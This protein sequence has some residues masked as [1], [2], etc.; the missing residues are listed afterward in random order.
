[1]NQCATWPDGRGLD[2]FE[3]TNKKRA[4]RDWW[5]WQPLRNFEDRLPH[6]QTI[7]DFVSE[8]LNEH[9]LTAAPT[10]SR[11]ELIRRLYFDL[12]GLPPSF[13]DVCSIRSRQFSRCYERIVDRLLSSPQF[14]ERWARHWLDL[15]RY[16]ETNGYER[17]AVKEHAWRYRDWVIDAFNTDMPYD[18][19]VI[20]AAC[21]R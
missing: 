21:G 6:A 20:S 12:V 18:Q 10:S 16:A 9:Q 14:G 19:F 11:R 1:M 17:D 3:Q 2:L 13:D 15:V 7:E 4:G 8:K 5:A